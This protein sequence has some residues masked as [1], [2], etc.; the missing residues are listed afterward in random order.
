VDADAA[1]V[2]VGELEGRAEGLRQSY[3]NGLEVGVA[4]GTRVAFEVGHMEGVVALLRE[5]NS[6]LCVV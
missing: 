6:M 2:R 1:F 3:D 5:V 4:Q